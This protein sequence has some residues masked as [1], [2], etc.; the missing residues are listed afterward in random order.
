MHD[1]LLHRRN[2]S[3]REHGNAKAQQKCGTRSR[4]DAQ[5]R[6]DGLVEEAG[7][8]VRRLLQD[9]DVAARALGR[10]HLPAERVSAAARREAVL[11]N[12]F[13]LLQ[14]DQAV[15]VKGD[16]RYKSVTDTGGTQP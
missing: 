12:K 4:P 7:V 13:T 14:R 1:A 2:V 15:V 5:Q 9:D 8:D 11:I 6:R 10:R 3:G 16:G